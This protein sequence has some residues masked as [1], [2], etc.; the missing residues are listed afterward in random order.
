MAWVIRRI[1]HYLSMLRQ[2]DVGL[3]R[4]PWRNHCTRA[5]LPSTNKQDETLLSRSYHGPNLAQLST[6]ERIYIARGLEAGPLADYTS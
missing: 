4:L 5:V 1:E 2:C 3:R 6:V